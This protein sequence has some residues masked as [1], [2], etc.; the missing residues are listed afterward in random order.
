M[1][2]YNNNISIAKGIGIILMV[3]GHA[4]CPTWMF[5]FIYLFHMPLFF[6][7]SGYCFNNQYIDDKK[8]FILKRIKTLYMPFIS[9]NVLFIILHNLFFKVHIHAVAYSLYDFM[10]I[11]PKVL[12]MNFTEIEL[13]PYWFLRYLFLASIIFVPKI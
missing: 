13:G 10:N 2:N 11:I 9:Y 5:Q 8:I 12:I 1:K 3:I 7:L 4:G 6:F